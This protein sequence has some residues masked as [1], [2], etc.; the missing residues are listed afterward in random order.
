MET[1]VLFDGAELHCAVC[2]KVLVGSHRRFCSAQCS[3]AW[4]EDKQRNKYTRKNSAASIAAQARKK[5]RSYGQEV[6]QSF[7]AR[8]SEQMRQSR[9]KLKQDFRRVQ[10]E[11]ELKIISENSEGQG[12]A[13]E[14]G[15][16]VS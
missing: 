11:K 3:K 8:Q 1:P 12:S 7:L 2:G 6:L 15:Q 4:Y 5:G 13:V 14:I 10:L 9:E 16:L